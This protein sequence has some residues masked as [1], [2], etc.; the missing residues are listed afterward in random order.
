M[1]VTRKTDDS[2]QFRHAPIFKIG[3]VVDANVVAVDT[4]HFVLQT[5]PRGTCA[6]ARNAKT[7]VA[8]CNICQLEVVPR[9]QVVEVHPRQKFACI[10]CDLLISSVARLSCELLRRANHKQHR[11][12]HSGNE[13][14]CLQAK[15]KV[16]QSSG[17][18]LCLRCKTLRIRPNA[19]DG[20]FHPDQENSPHLGIEMPCLGNNPKAAEQLLR[21]PALLP[22]EFH[23]LAVVPT[24]V[25]VIFHGPAAGPVAYG[26]LL[27]HRVLP[28]PN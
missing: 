21:I 5:R 2:G 10:R 11:G 27:H 19:T 28:Y 18:W 16:V 8:C 9:R 12:S 17:S 22:G 4:Q 14:T 26:S 7:R 13:P 20:N 25:G 24:L 6:Y 3:K 23:H 1:I 15:C